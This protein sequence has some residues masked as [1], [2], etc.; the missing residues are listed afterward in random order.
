LGPL[1]LMPMAR[2]ASWVALLELT[3]MVLVAVGKT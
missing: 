2:V 3:L 1:V